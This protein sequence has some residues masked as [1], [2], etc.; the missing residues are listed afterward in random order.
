MQALAKKKLIKE[1]K[2]D[3]HGRKTADTPAEWIASVPDYRY[4]S[5]LDWLPTW[6]DLLDHHSEGAAAASAA[7]TSTSAAP[8]PSKRKH[9]SDSD[10]E[11]QA[12]KKA[13]AV[14]QFVSAFC[15]VV[16]TIPL[17]QQDEAKAEVKVKKE[18]KDKEAEGEVKVKKEKKEKKE[19]SDEAAPEVKVKKEKKEKKSKVFLSKIRCL[20]RLTILSHRRHRTSNACFVFSHVTFL[21]LWSHKTKSTTAHSIQRTVSA[22]P[23]ALL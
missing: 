3:K 6:P 21:I 16:G 20:A 4:C 14:R 13:P 23:Q 11:T 1:G 22:A 18:K 5:V 2:L 15:M 12:A 10:G 19:K 17:L 7:A 8:T 9:D